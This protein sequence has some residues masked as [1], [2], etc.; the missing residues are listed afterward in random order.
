MKDC[1]FMS[2]VGNACNFGIIF[3]AF[4]IFFDIF[5]DKSRFLFIFCLKIGNKFGSDITVTHENNILTFESC[6]SNSASPKVFD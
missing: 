4:I 1:I 5:V 3:F 2:N 6:F